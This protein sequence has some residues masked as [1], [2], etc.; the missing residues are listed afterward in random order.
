M[1]ASRVLLQRS[2]LP[3]FKRE[4][5]MNALYILIAI[6]IFGVII[7]VHELGHFIFARIFGVTVNEFSI[8]MGPVLVSYTSKKTSIQ[9]SL[10]ALPFGGFVSMAGEDGESDDPNAFS[11]KSPW[12]RFII[13]AAG[14][15]MNLLLGVVITVILMCNMTLVSNTVGGFQEGFEVKSSDSGLRIG[16]EIVA[17]DGTPVHIAQEVIYEIMHE[18]YETIDVTVI[19]DGERLT[20]PVSFQTVAVD[21]MLYGSSDLVFYR[22]DHNLLSVLKHSFFYSIMTVRMIWDSLFDLIFGRVSVE[23]VS[24]PIGI[25]NEISS[26]VASQDISYLAYITIV[27]C[28]NVGVVNLLPIPALDGGRLLFLIVEMIRRKP[29]PEKVEGMV[30][31]IGL[32]LL[33]LLMVFIAFKD[34]I[35]LF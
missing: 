34:V 24:G 21:G 11:K 2:A 26:A 20:I 9:Y 14:A 12:K 3:K 5:K 1:I 13:L 4:H 16:D 31:G 23:A 19:R 33:L 8:G 27:I 29:L 7:F 32:M 6:L 22:E 17:V 25:T 10:R 15:V 18:G 35:N 30:H 28:M